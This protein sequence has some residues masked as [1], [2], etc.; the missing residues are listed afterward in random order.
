M[1]SFILYLLPVIT[2][3]KRTTIITFFRCKHYQLDM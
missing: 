2:A 1:K 3:H